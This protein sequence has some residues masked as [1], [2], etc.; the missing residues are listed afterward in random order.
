MKIIHRPSESCIC[1]ACSL[2]INGL[3]QYSRI[4]TLLCI[5]W[6]QRHYILRFLSILTEVC[7][8]FDGEQ[9]NLLSLKNQYLKNHDLRKMPFSK[10]IQSFIQLTH[11][12]IQGAPSLIKSSNGFP[13]ALLF[14]K[15]R[16]LNISEITIFKKCYFSKKFSDYFYLAHMLQL[17][18]PYLIRN[19]QRFLLPILICQN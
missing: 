12:V 19:H 5:T 9:Q 3:L 8:N 16:K 17:R 13:A 6:H 10:E 1:T 15:I 18:D 4:S 7:V 11:V 2:H 14:D